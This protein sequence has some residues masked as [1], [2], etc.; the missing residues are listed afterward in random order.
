MKKKYG[1]ER[2]EAACVKAIAVGDPSYRTVKGILIAG[3]ETEPQTQSTGDGGAAAFLHGPTRLFAADM[4]PV[5]T[6]DDRDDHGHNEAG[7]A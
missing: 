7:V 5:T 4:T 3:T 6:D 2:L 1:P